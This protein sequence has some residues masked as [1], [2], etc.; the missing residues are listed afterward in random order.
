M[1]NSKSILDPNFKY[2]SSA[3][4]DIRKTFARVKKMLKDADNLTGL[5]NFEKEGKKN[6]K[7]ESLH[8]S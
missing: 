4:T 8:L 1:R 5:S 6:G 7:R 2:V 3:N